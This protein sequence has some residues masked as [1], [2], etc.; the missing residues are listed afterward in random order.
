MRTVM[1]WV[2]ALACS[3]CAAMDDGS[4]DEIGS[5]SDEVGS[6]A[7]LDV[8]LILGQSN[9]VGGASV[10]ALG[11][12]AATYSNTFD[13]VR[14]AQEIN[15][16]KNGTVGPCDLSRGWRGLAPRAGHMGI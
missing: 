12:D 3:G 16:P 14:F 11:A 7:A 5:A 1:R 9:A 4:V 15:C 6:G 13:A 2:V 8:Y 10:D